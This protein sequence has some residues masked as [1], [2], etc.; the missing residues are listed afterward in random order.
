MFIASIRWMR[1]C[2]HKCLVFS[3]N[4]CIINHLQFLMFFFLF[5]NSCNWTAATA[6]NKIAWFVWTRLLRRRSCC[7][8]NTQITTAASSSCHLSRNNLLVGGLHRLCKQHKVP[9]CRCDFATKDESQPTDKV[10]YHGAVWKR[11]RRFNNIHV[12]RSILLP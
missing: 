9:L 10:Y 2:C 5:A 8:A 7:I 6:W 11:C 3:Y 4:V 12:D 1:R